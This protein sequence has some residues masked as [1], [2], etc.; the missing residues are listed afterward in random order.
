MLA[1]LAEQ[2]R[3]EAAPEAE[4]LSA[5]GW[6]LDG[7]T[8]ELRGWRGGLPVA[9]RLTASEFRLARTLMEL[10]G[11][12]VRR[13]ALMRR[14]Y[15]GAGTE[16]QERNMDSLVNKLRRRLDLAPGESGPIETIR[17]CGYRWKETACPPRD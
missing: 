15:G 17:G 2:A 4:R 7:E 11:R 3:R 6:T 14:L 9:A 13:E 5:G 8:R 12:T 16:Q 1:E 10:A